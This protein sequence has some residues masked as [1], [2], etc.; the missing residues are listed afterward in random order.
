MRLT[1]RNGTG[2]TRQGADAAEALRSAGFIATVAGDE[3]GGGAE[4]TVVRFP[5]SQAAAADLVSRWLAGGAKLEPTADAA[6]IEVVTG[7]DWDGVRSEAAPP[8]SPTTVAGLPE[9]TTTTPATT[10]P[11]G[12]QPSEQDLPSTSIDLSAHAC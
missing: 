2:V 5:P 10:A 11:A 12:E 1:V 4:G 6:G 3:P 7:V 8:T 9:P